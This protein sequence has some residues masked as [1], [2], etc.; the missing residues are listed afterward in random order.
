MEFRG[1]PGNEVESYL[2]GPQE[3][4]MEGQSGGQQGMLQFVKE[5]KKN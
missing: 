1:P 5:T 4:K 2:R 3:N